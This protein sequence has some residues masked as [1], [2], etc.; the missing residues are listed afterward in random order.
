MKLKTEKVQILY[1][2][3]HRV[4]LVHKVIHSLSICLSVF[5]FNSETS[6]LV[7]MY[8][9]IIGSPGPGPVSSGPPGPP[10]IVLHFLSVFMFNSGLLYLVCVYVI[11]I[12]SPGPG[13]GPVPSGPPGPLGPP[14]IVLH[15]LSVFMFNSG[16]LYLVCVYVIIIGSPGPGPGPVPSGPPDPGIP[17]SGETN[18]ADKE[19]D[20]EILDVEALKA[21]A[22]T[23]VNAV[24]FTPEE[25]AKLAMYPAII[26]ELLLD[27]GISSFSKF[28]YKEM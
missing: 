8:V 10:G 17:E 7:C 2:P 22:H 14:G 25:L 6:F 18:L 26:Y 20:D 28:Q 27:K 9:I 19:E 15:F 24:V 1:R 23:T 16:L 11:I 3:V 5:A 13:P 4:H 12:G 21:E